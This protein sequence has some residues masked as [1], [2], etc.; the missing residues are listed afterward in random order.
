ME[1]T[2][3]LVFCDIPEVGRLCKFRSAV[4]GILEKKIVDQIM[5][6]TLS[7]FPR[8][9][10]GQLNCFSWST[11]FYWRRN[12][13]SPH[14]EEKTKNCHW[15]IVTIIIKLLIKRKILCVE[16]ILS[17]YT[18]AHDHNVSLAIAFACFT[19]WADAQLW[20]T[21][22]LYEAEFTQLKTGSK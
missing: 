12:K 5:F 8:S 13:S 2:F 9:L 11:L 3:I 15:S 7:L 6:L 22:E 10:S 16:T 4:I 17:A 18:R 21:E 20:K 19:I 1:S 14:G